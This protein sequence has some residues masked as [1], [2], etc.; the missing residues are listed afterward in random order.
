[1]NDYIIGI[2]IGSSNICAAA[3]KLDKYGKMQIIGITSSKCNGVK[4][5]V[6]ID[7]D[8]TSESI[9]KCIRQLEKMIDINI[10]EA[11]IALP[12]GLSELIKSRG[13]VAVASEDGEVKQSD[14]KRVL[15]AAKII[16]IPNDKEIIGIIPEEY[17][18]D[19]YDKIKDPIGMSG[20]RLEV[21]AQVILAQ[22]TVVNN[23]LKS[24]NNSGIKVLGLVFEPTA[25]AQA[26]LKEEEIQR[27]VVLVDMGSDSTNIYNYE[28]GK[29]NNISTISLGGNTITNDISVCLKIPLSSAEKLK[30]K[31]GSVGL[32]SKT[33]PLKIEINTD[34]NN[35]K[36]IDYNI[37]LQIIEA[38]VDELL[39]MV[40][41]K[42]KSFNN[43]ENIS[44]IVMV[45]G[46]ISE[47][48]GIEE[49]SENLF[50]KTV[51]VGVPNYI[52][53]S[54]PMY[55]TVVGIVKDISSSIKGKYEKKVNEYEDKD[56]NKYEKTGKV[57]DS[58]DIKYK[59]TGVVSKIKEFFTDF[60]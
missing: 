14:V 59:N 23:F 12:G 30:K 1:M 42:L 36:K 25:I 29:L 51:R 26:V 17:I 8:S 19:G 49:F 43:Y 9:R 35:K 44:E 53:A 40:D 10:Q 55:V 32:L 33:K 18:I 20:I 5:G 2:D 56:I 21:D 37:L 48:K 24:V 3:G 31:Y 6:V 45:G 11:Y 28:G 52:G 38:R 13:V 60:F 7:I 34:Y 16:T 58:E 27:G 50:N 54:S 15:K 46:G 41:K 39:S 47:I 22:S 4:K 57:N